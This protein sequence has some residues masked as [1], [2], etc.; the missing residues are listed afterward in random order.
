MGKTGSRNRVLVE[1]DRCQKRRHHRENR[2]EPRQTKSKRPR[3]CGESHQRNR[4]FVHESQ[5]HLGGGAW[6]TPPESDRQYGDYARHDIT[7]NSDASDEDEQDYAQSAQRL[8]SALQLAQ[9]EGMKVVLDLQYASRVCAGHVRADDHGRADWPELQAKEL[10]SKLELDKASPIIPSKSKCCSPTVRRRRKRQHN[11]RDLR[12]RTCSKASGKCLDR[13]SRMGRPLLHPRR[14]PRRSPRIRLAVRGVRCGE[15]PNG[16]N[17]CLPDV[18]MDKDTARHT[19]STLMAS[20]PA[21]TMWRGTSPKNWTT[22]I[23][24]FGGRYQPIHHN[25]RHRGQHHRQKR[26]ETTGSCL[27][28]RLRRRRFR[29]DDNSDSVDEENAQ[30]PIISR[31]WGLYQFH[32]EHRQRQTVDDRHGKPQDLGI[33]HCTDLRATEHFGQACEA[34]VHPSAAMEGT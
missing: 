1:T 21:T 22:R 16:S 29:S 34:D 3:L 33:R 23:H 12:P 8:V 24:R 18:G 4:A 20:S 30:W 32:A 27:R 19:L 26:P 13:I 14:S 5:N 9:N 15:K 10:V 6:P 25:F 31:L 28:R 11:G 2:F 17:P 7:W